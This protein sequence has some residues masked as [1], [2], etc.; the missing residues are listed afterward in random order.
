MADRFME[1][2]NEKLNIIYRRCKFL[3][4]ILL[5]MWLVTAIPVAAVRF[6]DKRDTE[7]LRAKS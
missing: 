4:I 7:E 6:V 3:C 1:E 5:I 2:G